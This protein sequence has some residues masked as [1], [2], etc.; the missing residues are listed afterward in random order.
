VIGT[1]VK[2]LLGVV[3]IGAVVVGVAAVVPSPSTCTADAP[4]G[5]AATAQAQWDAW[6]SGTGGQSVT[7]TEGDATAVLRAHLGTDT[8]LVDPVVHFC[9]DGTAQ[10]SFGFKAG[11]LTLHGAADGTISA[12][13]PLSVAVTSIRVGALPSAVSDPIVNTVKGVATDAGSL[14]LAGP[15]RTV[16]VTKGQVVVAK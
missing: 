5:T 12:T 4:A 7:F 14:G 13:S 1:I 15:V 10:V 8:P 3:V 11:P 6:A 2:L 16:T 9:A